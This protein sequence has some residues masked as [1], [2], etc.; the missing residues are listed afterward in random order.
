[1]ERGT[2]VRKPLDEK[3]DQLQREMAHALARRRG[4]L[5]RGWYRQETRLPRGLWAV[6]EAR[7]E[8]GRKLLYPLALNLYIAYV[9]EADRAIGAGELGPGGGSRLRSDG[10]KLVSGATRA[11]YARCLGC[12]IRH[13]RRLDRQLIAVGLV[14]NGGYYP[15]AGDG[16]IFSPSGM[17]VQKRRRASWLPPLKDVD[18]VRMVDALAE[19]DECERAPAAVPAADA[20]AAV[21]SDNMR[22]A[23]SETGHLCPPEV[24]SQISRKVC[25]SSPTLSRGGGGAAVAAPALDRAELEAQAATRSA[26]GLRPSIEGWIASA[27]PWRGVVE[28]LSFATRAELRALILAD[29]KRWGAERDPS[30]DRKR[31]RPRR[32]AQ[33]EP[34]RVSPSARSENA[35]AAAPVR[36]ATHAACLWCDSSPCRRGC[37]CPDCWKKIGAEID[38]RRRS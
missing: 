12:S 24:V 29:L 6:F 28:S 2:C 17:R 8:D 11:Y 30:E 16:Y 37:D 27:V 3:A 9:R 38:A 19:P 10:A 20:C 34:R 13:I 32:N 36:Q 35:P 26:S 1:M 31:R 18:Y 4:E 15:Q 5:A 7:G 33:V 21:G 14:Q 22:S 25:A 23:P